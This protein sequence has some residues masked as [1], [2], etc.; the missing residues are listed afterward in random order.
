MMAATS[1]SSRVIDC[2]PGPDPDLV[3][4]S[5]DDDRS[6]LREG[7]GHVRSV[8]DSGLNF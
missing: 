3:Q 1:N 2:W 5:H 4:E 6:C 8:C 7:R